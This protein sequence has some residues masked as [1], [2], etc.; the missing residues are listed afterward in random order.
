MSPFKSL[1]FEKRFYFHILLYTLSR[2]RGW[3]N[4]PGFDPHTE[5]AYKKVSDGHPLRLWKVSTE[6]EAP[7]LEVLRR[8]V[9]ERHAWDPSLLQWRVVERLD[10]QAEIYQ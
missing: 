3:V 9:R 1:H 4:F 2:S 8:V 5:I 6:V 10:T 7:P